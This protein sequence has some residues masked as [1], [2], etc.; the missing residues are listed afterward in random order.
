MS[1]C[2]PLAIQV[3]RMVLSNTSEMNAITL[4][5]EQLGEILQIVTY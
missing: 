1:G 2:S 4:K 5:K 3:M